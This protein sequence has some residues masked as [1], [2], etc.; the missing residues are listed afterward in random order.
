MANSEAIWIAVERR[1]IRRYR[2]NVLVGC[3]TEL[4]DPTTTSGW[5][6]LV[7]GALDDGQ[8]FDAEPTTFG[9]FFSC[10]E[11]QRPYVKYDSRTAA[12]LRALEYLE[13]DGTPLPAPPPGQYPQSEPDLLDKLIGVQL[14]SQTK[15]VVKVAAYSAIIIAAVYFLAPKLTDTYLRMKPKR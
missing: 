8:Y 15:Q 11:P 14:S 1:H 3:K 9:D 13:A 4:R 10:G 5:T 2:P 7:V 12:A 6:E